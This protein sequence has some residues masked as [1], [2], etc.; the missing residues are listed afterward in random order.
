MAGMSE[1][2]GRWLI[3]GACCLMLASLPAQRINASTI[4]AA[5]IR[6]QAVA[7]A[8]CKAIASR[9]DAIPGDGPVLLRSY[10]SRQGHGPPAVAPLRSAAFTYDNALAV[11][12]LLACHKR[13][14][15]ERIGEALR[16]AARNDSRLRDAYLAGAVVGDK[17]RPN[18]WWNAQGHWV[19]AAQQY[20]GAYQGGTS[21]GNV[22][23]A[24]LALLAL[25]QATGEVRWRDAAVD[26]AAWAVAHASDTRGAGGF[27]GGM[28]SL[29]LKPRPALWKSTE[30]NIDLTALFEW[31]QRIGA[32][33]GHWGAEAKRARRFVTAQWETS[34]GH[35]W[36]GT[37]AD[38]IAAVHSPSALDVQLWAQLLPNAPNRWQRA[39]AWIQRNHSVGGGFSFTDDRAGMWT[40]GTA[41]AALVYRQVGDE[42]EA[43]KL[44][45]IIA[46]QASPNGFFYATPAPRAKA[47]YSFY[48]HQPCLAATAWAVIA[49]LN[50]NPYIPATRKTP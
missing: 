20:S 28:E 7:Q 48:Y 10:D 6:I 31:L 45:V 40:E 14:Q 37:T 13:P 35:F 4:A 8:G 11:I 3:G 49:A 19:V 21:S 29:P 24:A 27:N 30:H 39:L 23:W 18:G 46:Q 26:L 1:K 32:P 34:S 15:A 50:R 17:P 36:M 47:A 43:D 16:L 5:T 9:V 22:G 33:G 42:A 41:Q 38:G 12:A 2:L 25:H 44:F